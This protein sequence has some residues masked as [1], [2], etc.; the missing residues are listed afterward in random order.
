MFGPIAN[1][2]LGFGPITH[3]RYRRR[4]RQRCLVLRRTA[5][6]RNKKSI[7][8]IHA[9]VVFYGSFEC[10]IYVGEYFRAIILVGVITRMR[11]PNIYI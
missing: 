11:E 2:R 6:G 3:T 8:L 1:V 7:Q 5:V 9:C 4:F 10:G